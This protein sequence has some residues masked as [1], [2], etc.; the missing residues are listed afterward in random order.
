[1]FLKGDYC[2][3][4]RAAI[5]VGVMDFNWSSSLKTFFQSSSSFFISIAAE[6]SE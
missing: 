6:G 1:M 3:G 5:G 4:W 2:P